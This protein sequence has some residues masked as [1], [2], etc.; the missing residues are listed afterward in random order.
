MK[1]KSTGKEIF[2]DENIAKDVANR[3]NVRKKRAKRSYG[4]KKKQI[5]IEHQA[6][7]AYQCNACGY[8]H[9][10]KTKKQKK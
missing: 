1:C 3:G 9:I 10:S 8:W 6:I 4:M 5:R 7:Y 2:K